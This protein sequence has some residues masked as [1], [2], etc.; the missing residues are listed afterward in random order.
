MH[1]YTEGLNEPQKEAVLHKNGPLLIVAGAGAGKTKTLTHRIIQL[2]QSGVPAHQILAVTFTNKAAQEMRGR[3][4]TL[5]Q[6]E[7]IIGYGNEPF[8]GTFHSLGVYILRKE[9]EALGLPKHF[10]ILDQ[11]DSRSLIK[12]AIKARNLD[13]KQFDPKKIQSII[14]RQKGECVSAETFYANSNTA[15]FPRIVAEVWLDYEKRTKKASAFDFDDL[16]LK[17]L[18]LLR[19]NEAIREKYQEMWRYVHID[20]YQDTNTVQYE[21]SR[22]LAGK[23]RNICVVGDGDQCFPK[24]TRVSVK[25]GE[26]KIEDI[27]TGDEV[28]SAAGNGDVCLS[29][30]TRVIEK[31]YDGD[32]IK[33]TTKSGRIIKT[34]PEH[35][36]FSRFS[37]QHNVYYVYLM[38]KRTKGFRV[39]MVKS[40][41]VPGNGNGDVKVGFLVRSN[42]EKADRMWVI[43]VCET[44][45]EAILWENYYSFFY[46]IPTIVFHTIGRKLSLAQKQIDDLF[47]M[48]DTEKNAKRLFEETGL[49][50]DFPHYTPQGTTQGNTENNRL[51]VRLTM[52]SDKRKS[53]LHPFGLSRVSINTTDKK[54]KEKLELAGFK[55][56][57]G[58]R[59]DWRLEI[60]KLDYGEAENIAQKILAI[61]PKLILNRTA[62]LTEKGRFNFFPAASLREK[63]E[64][65]LIQNGKIITDEIQKIER[66]KYEGLVYDLDIAKTHNYIVNSIPVHNCVYSWRG[67]NIRNIIHFEKDYPGSKIVLLEE[68]YRSTQNILSAA[69]S[70]IQKNKLR[71]PKNLFTKIPGGEQISLYEAYDEN[72]EASFVAEKVRELVRKGVSYQNIAVLFRANYQSRALEE[73]MLSADIPYQVLGTKFFE[74]KEVKDVLAY[75]RAAFNPESAFDL[76]RIINVPARGLGEVTL[77]KILAGQ[78]D[79]LPAAAKTKVSDF[80]A[81]LEKIRVIAAEKKPSDT[82]K[83]ILKETG[84]E[85]GLSLGGEEEQERIENLYELVS[86][87]SKY[88][89]YPPEEG[90]QKLLE[91]AAL[92]SDQDSLMHGKIDTPRVRL[93]TVHASKGLEF[94][95][96]F[97]TGLEDGLFPH[98]SFGESGDSQNHKEEERRLFYVAI[99]RAK[100]RLFL[101]YASVR[102]VFGSRNMT[103]PSE[104]LNDIPEELVEIEE[105][106]GETRGRVVYI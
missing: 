22:L 64:T 104:F 29:K 101:T 103:V 56:R 34:T 2:I 58:K 44:K 27:K 82:V 69:N 25:N 87:A 3:I 53:V 71:V 95:T 81:L 24:N 46:G 47:G 68:N 62:L 51:N 30:V 55:T 94:E 42:Q 54:L 67:A 4:N 43:R 11:N 23:D 18:L 32:M 90:I 49:S 57:K 16:L 7:N 78:R 59:D 79:M 26:K 12:D 60:A 37:L 28:K 106:K 38:Y 45:P 33:I 1:D 83:Y 8:I 50:F 36:F 6:K 21:L 41:R 80:F 9:N 39:G 74:R 15:F 61:N 35:I 88:D 96:V 63:M 73:A 77:K 84:M 76:K 91:D 40:A 89:A 20:E 105:R 97:I 92:A 48:I 86:L 66:V 10:T 98:R 70:V 14:S 85:K 19:E 75:L 31:K 52:F 17:T 5:L 102:T 100:Q 72:D 65:A 93:M 13:P 99:T